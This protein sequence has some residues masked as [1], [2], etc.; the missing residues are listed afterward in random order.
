GETLQVSYSV[1]NAGGG[2]AQG[3]WLDSVFLSRDEHLD[4]SDQFLTR[5][6]HDGDLQPGA[7]YNQTVTVHLQAFE[8]FAPGE[9]FILIRTDAGADVTETDNANN[10]RATSLTV[11][12]RVTALT[13]GQPFSGTVTAGQAV[14]F[15]VSYVQG[16]PLTFSLTGLPT[17]G[18]V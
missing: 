1:R 18:T 13:L 15:A 7:S 5:V 17:D 4:A 9:W 12:Q 14:Y 10:V 6:T 8:G 2:I 3:R 16:Q 11:E